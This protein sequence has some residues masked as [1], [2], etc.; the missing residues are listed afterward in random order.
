[1][2]KMIDGLFFVLWDHISMTLNLSSLFPCACTYSGP[3][4][5]L[6]QDNAFDVGKSRDHQTELERVEYGHELCS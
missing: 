4:S 2:N 5:V 1:M 3:H 6:S